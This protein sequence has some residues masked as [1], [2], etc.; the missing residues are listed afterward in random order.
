MGQVDTAKP[1]VTEVYSQAACTQLHHEGTAAGSRQVVYYR[2]SCQ[3]QEPPRMASPTVVCASLRRKQTGQMVRAWQRQWC[4]QLG[5]MGQPQHSPPAFRPL[6]KTC[7]PGPG[8]SSAHGDPYQRPCTNGLDAPLLSPQAGLGPR[9]GHLPLPAAHHHRGRHCLQGESFQ[10]NLGTC[11]IKPQS[12]C[13][14]Q[15]FGSPTRGG[16]KASDQSL[17]DW[18]SPGLKLDFFF[19]F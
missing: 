3:S 6:P 8:G 7:L 16:K 9:R 15:R 1:P 2:G 5:T 17:E 13:G 19:F 18:V 11:S 14:C 10:G 4:L 12:L